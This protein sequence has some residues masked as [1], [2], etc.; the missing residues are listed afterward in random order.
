MCRVYASQSPELYASTSRSLRLRG[1]STS[2]R[3]ENVFWDVL[4]RI[5]ADEG[6]ST[7]AFIAAL[8]DEMAAEGDIPRNFTSVLR[9]ACVI[10][11]AGG[12]LT[13]GRLLA[14]E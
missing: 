11:L 4:D 13:S 2:I 14:A 7:P 9:S 6:R 8:H 3:L 1:H 12:D 10:Y 5:A